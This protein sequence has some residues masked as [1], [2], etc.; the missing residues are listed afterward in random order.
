MAN[1]SVPPPTHDWD[2]PDQFS[3]FDNF[4]AKAELW[5]AS[6]QV[7]PALQFYKIVLMLGDTGLKKWQKFKM[8]EDDRKD[9][10]EVFKKFRES[11]GNDISFCTARSTLY[12]TFQQ[13]E[14]ETTHELDIR[15]SK[16]IDEFAFRRDKVREHIKLDILVHACRYYEVKKWCNSQSDEGKHKLTYEAVLK[17][18]KEHEAA[19]REYICLADENPTMTT[20]FQQTK[21]VVIDAF[22]S[23]SRNPRCTHRRSTSGSRERQQTSSKKQAKEHTTSDG[24]CPVQGATCGYCK[25]VNHWEHVCIKKELDEKK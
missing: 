23:K 4:K 25:K 9:P 13:Q 24:T 16:L 8:S 12:H 7:E 10:E 22:K 3:T 14:K 11:L 6:E 18:A 2:A 17:K 15:L 20:A 5:L 19:V 1:Y 21:Q